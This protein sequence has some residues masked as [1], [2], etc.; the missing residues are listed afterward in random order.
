[1]NVG[2]GSGDWG[3]HEREIANFRELMGRQPDLARAIY[4]A[5]DQRLHHVGAQPIRGRE[6]AWD[7]GISA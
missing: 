7:F 3:A 4:E 6:A 1:V 5:A 2:I